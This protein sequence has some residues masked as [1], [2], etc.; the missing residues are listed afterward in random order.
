[1]QMINNPLLNSRQRKSEIKETDS[2]MRWRE[3]NRETNGAKGRE[4]LE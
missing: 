3:E 2:D 1:M 4:L